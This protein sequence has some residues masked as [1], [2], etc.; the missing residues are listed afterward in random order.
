MESVSE[1]IWNL[2]ALSAPSSS[3]RELRARATRTAL[4]TFARLNEKV[5]YESNRLPFRLCKGD[6]EKRLRELAAGERPL[7]P[8]AQ[9]VWDL[10]RR[11]YPIELLVDVLGEVEDLSW[12]SFGVEQAHAGAA[13]VMRHHPD[14]HEGS[15]MSRSTLYMMRSLLSSSEHDVKLAKL[16]DQMSALDSATPGRISGRHV[17]LSDCFAVAAS[18]LPFLGQKPSVEARKELMRTHSDAYMQ[19][20]QASRS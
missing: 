14:F 18:L 10:L 7:E 5:F 8:A 13:Q 4:V 11:G 9:Q 19:L 17:F 1:A 6:K 20:G 3:A 16:E 15:T 2:L 12:S